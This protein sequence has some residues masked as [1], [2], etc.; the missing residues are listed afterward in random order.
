MGGNVKKWLL[1]VIMALI[2][3]VPIVSWARALPP[4]LPLEAFLRPTG[5]LLALVGFVFL[6]FQ[7]VLSA[8]IKWIERGIGLDKLLALHRPFGIAGYVLLVLHPTSLLLADIVDGNRLTFDGPKI[9]GAL[10]LSVLTAAVGAA[11]LYRVLSLRYQTWKAVHWA[12]YVVLPIALAHS[13]GG[14]TDLT[15]QPLRGFWLALGGMYAAV[16]AGKLWTWIQTRRHPYRVA[17]V[18][19]ETHNTWSLSFEGRKVPHKP[20][21][22][23]FVRLIRD[24]RLSDSHPFTICSSP[25]EE[26]LSVTIK[27]SGDFASTVGQ[28][29]TGDRAYIDAPYGVFSCVDV[30]APA[31]LLIAG[32]IGI[33]PL[34]SMLRSLRDTG[35]DRRVLLV[36]SNQTEDDIAFRDELEQLAAQM[37][38]L[39]IVHVLSRQQDWPGEKGH[40]DAELLARYAK[41]LED[42][43]VFVCGPPQMIG[44]VLRALR[45][46]GV[47]GRRVH[48]ERFAL[49]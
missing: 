13:L 27:E 22:F 46:I 10:N 45:R 21:Q 47:P 19:Q 9:V 43:E 30:D 4:E 7:Y 31:L 20:G 36:W 6:F 32:G 26:R 23:L 35:A 40:V 12:N 14:G 42:P 17:D 39:Q 28:T 49:R 18:V 41:G 11:L 15:A 5:R 33:T 34:I 8:K 16:L 44:S 24:G 3:V 29:E 1:L 2:I 48:S 38:S 25:T 37:P